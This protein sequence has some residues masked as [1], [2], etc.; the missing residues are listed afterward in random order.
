MTA[1][2][3]HAH[4]IYPVHSRLLSNTSPCVLLLSVDA[5]IRVDFPPYPLAI[6]RKDAMM[7]QAWMDP[8][9][10]T[11]LCLACRGHNNGPI[12]ARD[13]L[14]SAQVTECLAVIHVL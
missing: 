7:D 9:I 11:I 14:V 13:G 3:T 2:A 1:V 8:A 5:P 6:A 10:T 12:A 4:L